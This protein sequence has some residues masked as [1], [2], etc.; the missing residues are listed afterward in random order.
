[1][2]SERYSLDRI[3]NMTMYVD[4]KTYMFGSKE[5]KKAKKEE[6]KLLDEA[7]ENG[8]KVVYNGKVLYDFTKYTRKRKKSK[9]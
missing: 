6:D 4:K 3:N 5:D 7:K 9:R 2:I 8:Y 1:M